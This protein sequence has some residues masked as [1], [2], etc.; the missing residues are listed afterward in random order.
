MIV[1]DNIF[2]DI[3]KVLE[4]QKLIFIDTETDGLEAYNGNSI[5]GVGVGIASGKTYYFPF[6]HKH[7]ESINLSQEHL[8]ELIKV[9]NNNSKIL[10][11]YNIKFDLHMMVKEGLDV[12]DKELVDV[13]VAARMTEPDRFP[14]LTLSGTMDRVFGEGSSD[15]DIETKKI[16]KT[17]KTNKI[18]WVKDFSTAPESILGPYCEE[19]VKWTRRLYYHILQQV[20][21]TGQAPLF[22]MMKRLTKTLFRMEHRGVKIDLEYCQTAID[23]LANKQKET[24]QKIYAHSGREFDIASA[25]QVGEVFNE[26]GITSPETTPKGNQSWNEVALMMIDHPMAGSIR[27]Y[28][29]LTK[30]SGTYLTPF[31]DIPY[32][33]GS[34]CNWGTV[35]GRLSCRNPNLQNIPRFI[36]YT[37]DQ[38]I[39]EERQAAIQERI[40]AMVRARRGTQGAN[41]GGSSLASWGF[42]GDEKFDDS[43][44]DQVAIRRL[45]VPRPGYKLVSM[46]YSQMEVRVF[47]SYL[48]SD[49]MMDMMNKDNFDFHSEAAK[50]AFKVTEDQE[51]FKIYRQF[52]KG[53]TFGILYGMGIKKLAIQLDVEYEKAQEYRNDYFEGIPGARRFITSVHKKAKDK[54]FVRNR[55][56]RLYN[57]PKDKEYTAVNYL[58]Q[59]TSGDIMSNRMNVLDDIYKDEDVHAL[60]QVHDEVIFEMPE[61]RL[62]EF[63]P[64]I[65]AIMED[66]ELGIPFKVDVAIGEPSWA[67][68]EDIEV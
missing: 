55:Y 56:G 52:A 6:R 15:Y 27:E 61:D 28:R 16:L 4:T 32:L 18:P 11:G 21:D 33:H 7:E 3:L 36:I 54:G 51:D 50:I 34:F 63:I 23:R 68:K 49:E 53:I 22:E 40:E 37:K 19:D 25:K 38:E 48:Q 39:S 5:C 2:K 60:I 31:V 29:T 45:F 65:K 42:S 57:I 9:L 67:Q 66:N 35:T 59:G 14:N 10:V 1:T 24:E 47:L 26:M 58:V 62:D 8:D 46:D 13:L 17:S 41:I 30:M 44:D 12:W 64:P 43:R 20:Q